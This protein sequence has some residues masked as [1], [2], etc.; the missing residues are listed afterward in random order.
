MPQAD[1]FL[2]MGADFVLT[3]QGDLQ[4]A[5]DWD[6]IR[7]SFE[8][9]V[10]TNAAVLLTNGQPQAADWIFNPTFGLSANAMLGQAFTQN[11][12]SILE[13]AVYQGALQAATGNSSVP[14][15]VTVNQGPS[16]NQI[17]VTVVIT[18][19]NGEQQSLQVILP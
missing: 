9:F 7:Q 19:D 3:S 8:R 12:I 16:P 15:I 4:L 11:F 5:Y 1:L 6:L 10:F 18:P 2:E 17:N 14:P 13:Q